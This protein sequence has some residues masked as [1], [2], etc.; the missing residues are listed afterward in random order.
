MV[1]LNSVVLSWVN[2]NKFRFKY[3]NITKKV[4]I[5]IIEDYKQFLKII[6]KLKLYLIEFEENNIIK[7]KNYFLNYK[8]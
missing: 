1:E 3:K 5:K 4:F 6:K 7:T 2:Y 8:I